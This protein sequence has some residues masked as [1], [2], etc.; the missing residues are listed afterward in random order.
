MCDRLKPL[1]CKD[2]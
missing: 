2:G 1:V